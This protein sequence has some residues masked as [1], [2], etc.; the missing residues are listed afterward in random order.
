MNFVFFAVTTFLILYGRFRLFDVLMKPICRGL[1]RLLQSRSPRRAA[2][3]RN[4]STLDRKAGIPPHLRD[5]QARWESQ[6][7]FSRS[8]FSIARSFLASVVLTVKRAVA[9]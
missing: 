6:R 3:E 1:T 2:T 8:V 7:T 5:S 9:R 4:F